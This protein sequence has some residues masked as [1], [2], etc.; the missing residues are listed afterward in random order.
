MTVT[1][2]SIDTRM[3]N[4]INEKTKQIWFQT[5]NNPANETGI[6]LAG[7]ISNTT[8]STST[9]TTWGFNTFI[10]NGGLKLRYNQVDLTTLSTNALAFYK[11]NITSGTISGSVKA[12][13]LG[14]SALTFYSPSSTNN[15]LKKL[16]EL[17]NSSLNFY[18]KEARTNPIAQYN[19]N[20]ILLGKENKGNML[21]QPRGVYIRDG[22]RE[23]A[24]FGADGCGFANEHDDQIFK[25][26]YNDTMLTFNKTDVFKY[27]GESPF[28]I[29]LPWKLDL[30]IEMRFFKYI[31]NGEVTGITTTGHYTVDNNNSTITLDATLCEEMQS[32]N[33]KYVYTMYNAYGRF[34]Y[35]VIGTASNEKEKVGAFASAIGNDNELTALGNCSLAVGTMNSAS[36]ENSLAG[37]FMSS[38]YHPGGASIAYGT[39]LI[40]GS[41]GA[42]S[43]AVFG[44]YNAKG[45]VTSSEDQKRRFCIGNGTSDSARSNAFEVFQ[46]GNVKASGNLTLAG[47]SSPIGTIYEHTASDVS[48]TS[49][50]A[51]TQSTGK[52]ILSCT[53]EHIVPAGCWV[54]FV[55]V[56]FSAGASTVVGFNMATSNTSAAWSTQMHASEQNYGTRIRQ[57]VTITI[58]NDTAYYVRAWSKE[59]CTVNTVIVRLMRIR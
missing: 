16:M 32:N 19:G 56:N 59:G 5:S 54:G 23:L 13:E 8:F 3:F 15:N 48:L 37:G 12:M 52:T 35:Y 45:D 34:P 22:L 51:Q 43:E 6:H 47:H 24:T 49:T 20:N 9:P 10:E 7:G 42:G 11:P 57:P 25:V 1:R 17:T 27:S 38:T 31:P 40:A 26:A 41:G 28:I 36:G 21:I 50:A 55:Y 33:V 4:A 30:F 29:Q 14:T 2:G 58:A 44:R 46:N 39:G 53:G 18:D